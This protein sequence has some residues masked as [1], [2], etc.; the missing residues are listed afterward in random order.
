MHPLHVDDT[1]HIQQILKNMLVIEYYFCYIAE[2]MKIGG[3]AD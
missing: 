3:N 1:D 2:T